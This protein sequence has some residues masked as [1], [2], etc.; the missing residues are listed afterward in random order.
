MVP[1]PTLAPS[2]DV[3]HSHVMFDSIPDTIEAIKRGEFVIVLDDE[4]RENEGDLIIPAQN[5]TTEQMAWFIRHTSGFICISLHPALIAALDIPMMVP[6]NTEKNKTAY[7]VTV[8]YLHG[9]TTGIS[10]HDRALT[11]RK[12]AESG[13]SGS[14]RKD[15][16][17]RPGHLCPLRYTEGGVRRRGGHTEASV[18]LAVAAGLAPAALLSTTCE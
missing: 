9:T 11:A 8:D 17:A 1:A 13:I 2:V 14:V 18:D 16:F 4:D 3:A 5:I 10:A 12:L 7:T 15:D 6:H